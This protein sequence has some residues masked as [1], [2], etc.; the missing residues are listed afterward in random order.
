MRHPCHNENLGALVPLR[1]PQKGDS[2]SKSAKSKKARIQVW[3]RA[4]KLL[5]DL[6]RLQRDDGAAVLGFLHAVA[7][8]DRKVRLA[9]AAGMQRRAAG[10]HLH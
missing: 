3:I 7:G 4:F 8:L 5:T 2:G 1:Q 9:H 6:L 10:A